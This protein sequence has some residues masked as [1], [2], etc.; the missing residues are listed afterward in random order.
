MSFFYFRILYDRQHYRLK[1]ERIYL[2]AVHERYRIYSKSSNMVIESNRPAF[3]NR[4]LRY[5]RPEWKI[6][7]GHQKWHMLFDAI[8]KEVMN[9]L[10]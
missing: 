6:I 2:D 9:V 10:K 1:A 4:G 3:R 5:V 7:E 8:V